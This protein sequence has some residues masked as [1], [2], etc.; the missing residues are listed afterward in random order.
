MSAAV[1][2]ILET[3][4]EYIDRLQGGSAGPADFLRYDAALTAAERLVESRR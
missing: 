1:L 4:I 3:L 2:D